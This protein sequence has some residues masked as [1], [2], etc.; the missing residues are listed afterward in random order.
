MDIKYH[1]D[2]NFK[3]SKN[4]NLNPISSKNNNRRQDVS[5]VFYLDGSIYASKVSSY[6]KFRSFIQKKTMPYYPKAHKYIEIDD[7]IDFKLA[8]I[9][10]KYYFNK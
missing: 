2:F 8:E 3:L 1:P 7:E 6:I 4:N 5:K 9:I 10:K